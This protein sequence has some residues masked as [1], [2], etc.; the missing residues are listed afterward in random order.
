M[1]GSELSP[2]MSSATHRGR[3]GCQAH[4]RGS[5][6]EVHVRR[7]AICL[8]LTVMTLTIWIPTSQANLY[9][10]EQANCVA[11]NA[12]CYPQ[13]VQGYFY[14][15]G[16]TAQN[17]Q[18]AATYT[19]TNNINPSDGHGY[20]ETDWQQSDGVAYAQD[21]GQTGW[22]G[23]TWCTD[24][25]P[26]DVCHHWVVQ[27]NKYGGP[28]DQDYREHI[29]CHEFGHTMGLRHYPNGTSASCMRDPNGR[30]FTD[31]DYSHIDGYL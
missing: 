16:F 15:N 3:R 28:F 2:W 19:Y 12:S 14:G 4:R 31:H 29:V 25:G 26:G 21:Y 8:M 24:P 10:A 23:Q 20:E 9:G 13:Q 22:A 6:R 30:R 1:R 5:T 18:D 7:I 27:I 11:G 17:W